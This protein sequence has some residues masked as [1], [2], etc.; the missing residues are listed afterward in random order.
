MAAYYRPVMIR[1]IRTLRVG[2]RAFSSSSCCRQGLEGTTP[3]FSAGP[4]RRELHD[5]YWELISAPKNYWELTPDRKGLQRIFVFKTF[6]TTWVGNLKSFI[7]GDRFG[8]AY[9]ARNYFLM[10][11]DFYGQ[12]FMHSVA[13]ESHA[14]KHHPEWFNVL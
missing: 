1:S 11:G 3:F 13:K 9:Q 5:A 14:R 8:G 2:R 4:K 6:K 12:E 7:L 10:M